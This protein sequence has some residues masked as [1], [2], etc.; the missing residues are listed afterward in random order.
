[1]MDVITYLYMLG[2]KLIH[3]SK[4][5]P[6]WRPDVINALQSTFTVMQSSPRSPGYN[7]SRE[8]CLLIDRH[9]DEA[10]NQD[11]NHWVRLTA[12]WYHCGTTVMYLILPVS[13]LFAQICLEH[14]KNTPTISITYCATNT[15]HRS[16]LVKWPFLMRFQCPA[17][18]G[19]W[20]SLLLEAPFGRFLTTEG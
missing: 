3:V 17:K 14:D 15:P 6:R 12:A 4:R 10:V 1:M 2:L 11:T 20:N 7:P 13:Y 16:L 8:C 5:G 18:I 9:I 19:E